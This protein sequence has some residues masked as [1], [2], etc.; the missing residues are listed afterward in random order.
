MERYT[1]VPAEP[2]W[3]QQPAQAELASDIES[4]VG[5]RKAKAVPPLPVSLAFH[6]DTKTIE[7]LNLNSASETSKQNN[8]LLAILG[9]PLRVLLVIC[10][11][12]LPILLHR[13]LLFGR[14]SG[15]LGGRVG[16]R[17]RRWR[18]I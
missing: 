18:R 2:E 1:K 5:E 4:P 6:V 3:V 8:Y 17:S 16:L 12:L 11:P 10:L 7:N 15:I 14:Q 13:V 9:M